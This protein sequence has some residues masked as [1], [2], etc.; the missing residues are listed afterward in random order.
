MKYILPMTCGLLNFVLYILIG[1]FCFI[2]DAHNCILDYD[3]K[4]SLFAVYD[5]HGGAEVAQYASC[6]LPALVQNKLYLNQEFEK[7]LRKAYL[8]F[9]DSLIKPQVVDELTA[10]REECNDCC[11]MLIIRKTV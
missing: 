7:A 5:G 9:D 1:Y 8:D 4:T 6:K 11:G 3:K 2:Q 10:L